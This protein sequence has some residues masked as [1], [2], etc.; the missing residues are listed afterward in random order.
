VLHERQGQ[1]GVQGHRLLYK[2]LKV[3]LCYMRDKGKGE[4]VLGGEKHRP[5][6]MLNSVLSSFLPSWFQA[7]GPLEILNEDVQRGLGRKKKTF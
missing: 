1:V 4:G 7:E 6:K 3:C 5:Q 2:E